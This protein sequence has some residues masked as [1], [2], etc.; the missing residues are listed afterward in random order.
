M[1]PT[2]TAI[3]ITAPAPTVPLTPGPS[4]AGDSVGGA[5]GRQRVQAEAF[6]RG[7]P[8]ADALEEIEGMNA[9]SERLDRPW[10]QQ[11]DCIDSRLDMTAAV[12]ASIGDTQYRDAESNVRLDSGDDVGSDDIAIGGR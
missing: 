5:L 3:A 9:A 4:L 10:P 8:H 7:V 2:S 11:S 1:S 6:R 12:L